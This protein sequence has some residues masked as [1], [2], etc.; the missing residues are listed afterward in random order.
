MKRC[1]RC[2]MPETWPGISFDEEGVCNICREVEKKPQIDWAERQRWLRTILQ[3]YKEYKRSRGNKYDCLV[4][5]SGGKDSAYTLWA[6]VKKYGMKPLA[7]TFDHGFPLP[8]A[9]EW[10]L[11]E[12][13]KKLD[14]DHLRFTLGNGLRN[15]LC[16]TGSEVN[17]DFCWHC[18]VGVVAY[19]LQIAVKYKI[20]LIIYG[21]ST[22]E[23]TSYYEYG[24][25]DDV[26]ERK[27]N[28]M[29]VNLGITAEDMAGMINVDMR[30]LSPFVFP[31]QKEIRKNHIRAVHLGSFIKWDTK[32]Q[33]ELIRDELGWDGDDVEGVP[34]EYFYEKVE[35]MLTGVRD[36]LKY[37]KRGFSRATHLTSIDVRHGRMTR[38]KAMELVKEYEG[39]RPKS[40]DYFLK[41]M[42]MTE[43]EFMEIALKHV[44]KPHKFD[45]N[46]IKPDK[47][48]WDQHLWFVE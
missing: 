46:K 48:L 35:C 28:R 15:A 12:V 21:E 18:H 37:I 4:G 3:K 41:I 20:P 40:L 7:V 5:Y 45:K 25:E 1:T 13:P 29:G 17:G 30:D 39:K 14:C 10:N 42:D 2:V 26:G 23:Y 38:E 16:R 43:D 22:S 11:M 36:Y 27:V 31:S 32:K 47:E 8:P 9:G 33:S 6:A 24:E 34:A 19:P 44:I